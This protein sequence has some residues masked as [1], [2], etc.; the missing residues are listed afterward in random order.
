VIVLAPNSAVERPSGCYSNPGEA[1]RDK[2]NPLELNSDHITPSIFGKVAIY[3][4]LLK[5]TSCKGFKNCKNTY[6][7]FLFY[8]MEEPH[9]GNETR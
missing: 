1:P 7:K 5:Q 8:V 9:C 6:P 2:N 3:L 4:G